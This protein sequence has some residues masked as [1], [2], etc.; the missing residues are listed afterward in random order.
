MRAI[1][2]LLVLLLSTKAGAV[3]ETRIWYFEGEP[4]GSQ[5]ALW[6][7]RP[8]GIRNMIFTAYMFSPR[9]IANI[10][11]IERVGE[12]EARTS[13][14]PSRE[15]VKAWKRLAAIPGMS[16]HYKASRLPSA[17]E[18]SILKEIGFKKITF[19][20]TSLPARNEAALLADLAGA[21]VAL[22]MDI[23][24]LP[25][26]DDKPALM[27]VPASVLFVHKADYWPRYIQMDVMNLL[28]HKHVLHI[29]GQYPVMEAFPYLHGI[30]R[31]QRVVVDA[32]FEPSGAGVWTEF[33]ALPV[34]WRSYRAVPGASGFSAF[35][36]SLSAGMR[37][38]SVDAGE[39]T[40]SGAEVDRMRSAGVPV[41]WTHPSP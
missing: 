25:N 29:S 28:P 26:F 3:I 2:M 5:V 39:I 21:E 12:L 31:L 13:V 32:D 30:K 20:L 24:R 11:A 34:Q 22:E 4:S 10:A 19:N 18:H 36:S 7:A 15:S 1:Y 33:G 14:F 41:A 6:N 23:G 38:V 17:F 8:D 40:L 9:G 16:I 37:S 35:A 27:N